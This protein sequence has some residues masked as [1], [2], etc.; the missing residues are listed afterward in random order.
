[1]QQNNCPTKLLN[2]W[3]S[4]NLN[5]KNSTNNSK[6][7]NCIFG[8]V[9]IVKYIYKRMWMYSGYEI[10]FDRAA[11][12]KFDNDFPRNIVNF[13]L[14]IR[15]RLMLIIPIIFFLG[16]RW[17]SNTDKKN[18]D[19]PNSFSLGSISNRF[20]TTESREVS[21]KENEYDFSVYYNSIYKSDI[22]NIYKHLNVKKNMI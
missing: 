19:I 7:K 20:G 4:Y 5:V 18:V 8:A 10:T 9:N 11:L 16:A 17:R 22:L 2:A 12:W 3:I 15:H 6:F 14:M 1:M 13:V 21:L